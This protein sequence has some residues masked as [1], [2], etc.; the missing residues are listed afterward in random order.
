VHDLI[1]QLTFRVD[2]EKASERYSFRFEQNAVFTADLFC[3]IRDHR[4]ADFAD[5]FFPGKVGEFAVAA[6]AEY[7]RSESLEVI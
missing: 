7:L 3:D 4:I 1:T 2:D 5:L 6:C